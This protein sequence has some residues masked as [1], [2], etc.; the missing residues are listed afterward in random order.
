MTLSFRHVPCDEE[1]KEIECVK[2]ENPKKRAAC[3]LTFDDS[4]AFAR[5]FIIQLFLWIIITEPIKGIVAAYFIL[6][7]HPSHAITSEIDEAI[8]PLEYAADLYEL[9]LIQLNQ[10]EAKR[11]RE[12]QLFD[13]LRSVAC[14]LAALAITMGLVVFYRDTNAY[15]Y[16]QQ[17]RSLLNVDPFPFGPQA[18]SSINQIDQFWIWARNSLAPGI[19]FRKFRESS[20]ALFA[21]W[22]DGNPAWD[23]RGYANDKVSR[24]MG[25]GHIRQVR[26]VVAPK[27]PTAPELAQYFHNCTAD[28]SHR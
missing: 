1:F 19:F 15:Y 27:C 14:L 7:W 10:N 13:T 6:K 23:M 18:F 26:S 11:T 20:T 2:D 17:V 9:D 22:Y 8:L 24:A 21:K 4:V 3:G 25:I 28:I 5:R 12:E 16:Q